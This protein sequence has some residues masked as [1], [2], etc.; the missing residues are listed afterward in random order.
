MRK[1]N[2]NIIIVH[3][4]PFYFRLSDLSE[5]FILNNLMGISQ[6]PMDCSYNPIVFT[7]EIYNITA[8]PNMIFICKFNK[9]EKSVSTR[10]K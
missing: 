9:V 4:T 5:S 7:H 3:L 8:N 6:I 2:V 10:R 1:K